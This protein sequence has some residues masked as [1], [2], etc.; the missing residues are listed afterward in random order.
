MSKKNDATE[1][2]VSDLQFPV[3][4]IGASAGGLEA[5]KQ[6]LQNIPEES[7]MAYVF[8][9]HLSPTHETALPEILKKFSNIPVHQIT[10]DIHLKE[11]NFYVI[12]ANKIVVASDGVLKLNPLK[13]NDKT[14][15][16]DI[17]FSSLAV[18]H[19]SY[20]V[21]IVLSGML[22]DGT[23]GL[24]VIKA[25]GGITFAQDETSAAYDE[26]PQNAVK[27][28]AVDFVLSPSN[29]A[30]RLLSISLPFYVGYTKNEISHTIQEQEENVFK[31][32]LAVLRL[33]RGVDFTYY[34]SSTL[35]RRILR[36]MAL[37]GIQ[38]PVDYLAFIRDSNA[39]QDALYNDMLIS[40]T[41]FFRDPASFEVLCGNIV[42]KLVDEKNENEP[43]RIW[44]AGCATGEEAYSMA[45]CMQEQLGD[46]L[47]AVKIQIFATDISE[48]AIAK[49]R[50]G[51]YRT[52]DLQGVSPSRLE[53][54]FTKIDGSYQVNK[55]IRDM[56]VFAHHNF[57]KEPPFS[58]MDLVSCRN[59]LIYMEPVLQKR[60]LTTFHYAL[61]DK[62]FLMLGKSESIGSYTDL[63]TAYNNSEK[64][65]Q[66]KGARGRFM[67]VASHGSEQTFRDIDHH[68]E[69][70]N[71]Q[72]DIFKLADNIVIAMGPAGVLINEQYDIVQFR[73]LTETWLIPSPG[74]PSLNI[75]KMA[76]EGL[77]FEIRNLLHLAKK[78]NVQAKKENV[79]F[80][81]N[82]NQNNVNIAV[83]SITNT[84]GLHYL[85]L[86]EKG[87]EPAVSSLLKAAKSKKSVADPRDI[88]LEQ[89]EQEL[90][91]NRIDM[92]M[93]TEEQEAVNEE[94]QSANEE[95]LSG[96]EELQSLNEE[97]ETSK[98]ELQ[99]TNEEITI[100]NNELLNRNEQLNNAHLYTEGIINTIRDP[101]IIL[102]SDL[103]VKRATEGFYSK[104]KVTES[105]TEGRYFY[106]LGNGQWN[107]PLLR[108]L[109]ESILPDKKVL[110]NYEVTHV[111]P[112]I[113][114]KV[115]Y[116]NTRFL[117]NVNGEQLILLAIEDITDK[118]KIEEG[119]A[120]VEKLF[121]E[122]K[123][124]L[125]LAVD[126]AGL[127]IWDYNPISGELIWDNRCKEMFGLLSGTEIT[128]QN[129]IN[130]IH[131]ED[132]NQVDNY[133][134]QVLSGKNN[135]EYEEEFRTMDDD[136]KKQRWI[137]FK[138]KAYF[139]G[140]GV[141]DRFVGTSLDVTEQKQLDIATRELLKQKDDFI[142][143]ASHELKT[144]ITA[145]S[146][147][148]QLLNKMKDNPNGKVFP[149]LI[150]RSNRSLQKVNVLIKDLLTVTHFNQGHLNLNRRHFVMAEIVDDC[151]AHVHAE[152]IYSIITTGDCDLKVYADE[153]RID[154]VIVNFVNNAVK[155]APDSKEIIVRIEKLSESAKIS[156]ID[157]GPGIA[158]DKIP[159]LFD[160]YFRTN[161]DNAGGQFGL[162]LGL[163]ISSEI[164]KKHGG[165]IGVE[166]VIGKGS[167]FW[168]TL[169]LNPG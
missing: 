65:F 123:E 116:L 84:S 159:N 29:I 147:S 41:N 78:T 15:V 124:R 110:N 11:N 45:I 53:Q 14:K 26:M 6:F 83:T 69:K 115:M 164:V 56:C 34:K 22:N 39:E 95:L 166:S 89:L 145:L 82:G 148:L 50:T 156:V 127:G 58:K 90:S 16:I 49:A 27:G 134:K 138:G 136:G 135:G 118:R 80:N 28:K 54:F 117:A 87:E 10:D 120:Q 52:V 51:V 142:S 132:R 163:Y 144:P 161:P 9:Q 25:Y 108:S 67:Q 113:G 130:L 112:S 7:G 146:A 35:K 18:V 17:F 72:L 121:E 4:G 23:L 66:R 151:C 93:I 169:P 94:L 129:F 100:V 86:F 165:E 76:R 43:F 79:L 91:Q 157:K 126:A 12:P 88:R 97:L 122:S 3:V 77:A 62:G 102:D 21:G 1:R 32:L 42:P 47:G 48:I 109:L 137:K 57:L 140:K 152:G 155:Y 92:R 143:I 24:Q 55:T 31:Q 13:D 149:S 162:G 141:I 19:Q 30:E 131:P 61:N 70:E 20:A 59:V 37:N 167:T 64:I 46:G 96:S 44:I 63:Y 160:R 168:F 158:P 5:V 71:G 38:K 104:F 73:G 2:L 106:Q 40:V 114:R 75:L 133:L 128:Y 153:D 139:N 150:E 74:K 107:I 111:F 33:R 60:A 119:L 81:A 99:S 154:Q 8:V 105:E 125:K 85:V 36:R 98:E 68:V 101:L 103:K